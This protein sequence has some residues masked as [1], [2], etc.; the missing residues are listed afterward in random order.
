[1]VK[2]PERRYALLFATAAHITSCAIAVSGGVTVAELGR[3]HF[4]LDEQIDVTTVALVS[5]VIRW[6]EDREHS[7]SQIPGR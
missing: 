4:L 7:A 5:T 3:D 6:L 2:L 1:M